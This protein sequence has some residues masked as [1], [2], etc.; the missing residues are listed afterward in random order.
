M[1]TI[2]KLF[3]G[4]LLGAAVSLLGLSSVSAQ[5]ADS[6]SG[7]FDAG[8]D[9]YSSYVFRGVKFGSGPALQPW[10]EYSTGNLA[11]GAWG[12]ASA[13]V[14]EAAEMDL[15]L[16]YSFDFGLSLGVTDYYY[17]FAGELTGN[18]GQF[19]NYNFA[20]SVAAHAL[21]INV[22]YEVGDFSIAANI[23]P[24][25]SGVTD[26]GD[27]YIEA[28]YAFGNSSVFIGAGNGWHTFDTF[29]STWNEDE[30]THDDVF[31]VVNLGVSTEKEIQI[32]DKFSLPVSGAVIV[33]PNTEQ[34]Y[35]TVGLS[36]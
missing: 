30:G 14:D 10:V 5:D 20:D 35:I 6:T 2:T 11:I 18:E 17:P 3:K 1:T 34:F 33:N 32:T 8:V 23:I 13:G 31:G 16:S 7:P 24:L 9:I 15:Y 26:G 21:E 4:A 19:L 22:G 12:S 29:G 36:L 27:I 28:G 25:A